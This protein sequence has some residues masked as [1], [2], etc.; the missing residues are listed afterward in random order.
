LEAGVVVHAA[1]TSIILNNK[2]ASELLGLSDDQLNGKKAIDSEWHFTDMNNKRLPLE[3]FPVNIINRTK[4]HIRN[5][6]LGVYQPK[7]NE[8]VWLMVN[9]FPTFDNEGKLTEIIISFIDFSS[10]K[11]AEDNLI[12]AKEKAEEADKLKSSFL[13]NMSHE[14]RTPMNGIWVL[15]DCCQNLTLQVKTR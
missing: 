10:R 12:I 2:K 5:Y 1:D 9:G 8:K 11:I 3:E 14:I 6:V 15:P 13:A 4:K 7:N